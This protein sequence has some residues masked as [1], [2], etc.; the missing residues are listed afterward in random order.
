MLDKFQA[1]LLSSQPNAGICYV[2][3]LRVGKHQQAVP[4]VSIPM[5]KD[6]HQ[7]GTAANGFATEVPED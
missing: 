5:Y 3:L 4:S 7:L 6:C 2:H 1:L